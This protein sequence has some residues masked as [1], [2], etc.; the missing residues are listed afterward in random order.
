MEKLLVFGNSWL[1]LRIDV[2]P[3]ISDVE[4]GQTFRRKSNGPPVEF[5]EMSP[6]EAKGTDSNSGKNEVF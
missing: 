2:K 6:E 1:P 3:I 4:G 5:I